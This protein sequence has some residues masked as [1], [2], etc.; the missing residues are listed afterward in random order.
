MN[1]LPQG[2]RWRC[3][4]IEMD[5]YVTVHPVYLL[6]R[7]SF[8]VAQMIFG[9]PIFQHDMCYDP[10]VVFTGPNDREYGEWMSSQEATRIQVSNV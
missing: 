1:T 8:D 5:E 3:T 6:W 9:N 10:H 7:D 4:K 2:P